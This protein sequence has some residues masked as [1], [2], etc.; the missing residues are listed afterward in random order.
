MLWRWR[1][2]EH[3]SQIVNK[4]DITEELG[5]CAVQNKNIWWV[6]NEFSA[7]IR[8]KN[9][10]KVHSLLFLFSNVNAFGHDA[11]TQSYLQQQLGFKNMNVSHQEIL[12]TNN[13]I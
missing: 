10:P 3:V 4:C 6:F 12:V 7:Y 13:I 8:S 5:F 1:D 9:R 11:L 2:N